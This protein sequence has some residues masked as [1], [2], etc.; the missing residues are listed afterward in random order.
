MVADTMPA[1]AAP[2]MSLRGT[3]GPVADASDAPAEIPAV[4]ASADVVVPLPDDLG[5]K[6]AQTLAALSAPSTNADTTGAE[7]SLSRVIDDPE[8][9]GALLVGAAA[10]A[11]PGESINAPLLT[12]E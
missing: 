1:E 2:E 8:A 5:S 10:A 3:V 12:V 7:A 4:V 9:T 11:E 6:V